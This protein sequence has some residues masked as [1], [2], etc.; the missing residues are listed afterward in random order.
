MERIELEFYE[1]FTNEYGQIVFINKDNPHLFAER[2]YHWQDRI[3][4]IDEC[5]STKSANRQDLIEKIQKLDENDIVRV[6]RFIENGCV[7]SLE[8]LEQSEAE[9]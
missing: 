7:S 2:P 6:L 1:Y 4:I 9:E 8:E 5:E 3:I